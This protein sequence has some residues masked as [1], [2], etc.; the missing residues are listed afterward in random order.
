MSLHTNPFLCLAILLCLNSTKF[1]NA[2]QI[3]CICRYKN[4]Y[5][6]LSSISIVIT[7]HN[8]CVLVDVSQTKKICSI[9]GI[10]LF[11]Q[12]SAYNLQTSKAS[13]LNNCIKTVKIVLLQ[14]VWRRCT[15]SCCLVQ[16]VRCIRCIE[17]F[18][19]SHHWG[20]TNRS[21]HLFRIFVLEFD[22]LELNNICYIPLLICIRQKTWLE[23]KN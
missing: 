14:L 12:S 8:F 16:V 7:L 1:E 10:Q 6:K 5:Y 15:F 2:G 19:F 20:L 13:L 9:C 18:C 21:L 4:N 3:K 11:I 23:L 17:C 22:I